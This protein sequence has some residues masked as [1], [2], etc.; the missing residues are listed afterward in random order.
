MPDLS[1]IIPIYN[2]PTDALQRCFDSVSTLQHT[3]FEVILVDDGSASATGAFCREYCTKNSAFRYLFKENG[4]VSSARNYGLDA[5]AGRYITFVDADDILIGAPIDAA[6][7]NCSSDMVVFDVAVTEQS[8][9]SVWR[10]LDC[11]SGQVPIKELITLLITS[12]RLNSPCAKLYKRQIIEDS[13]LRFHTDFVTGEDWLFVCDFLEHCNIVTYCAEA[14]YR[15]FRDSSN[16]LT[17]TGRYPDA[18][19]DNTIAMYARKKQISASLFDRE[20]HQLHSAAA[21]ALIEN[22]FNTAANLLLLKKLT[23][24]RKQRI[25]SACKEAQTHLLPGASKK[26]R[27]KAWVLAH[28]RIALGPIAHLRQLYLSHK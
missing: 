19:V 16:A 27:M 12:S 22:L 26:T 5:A 7:R 9:E 10:G 17:R 21:V 4:G 1:I 24:Q 2:T 28:F 6:M 14:S 18:M 13:G 8:G 20:V 23:S 25:L 11:P 15:Y 3:D